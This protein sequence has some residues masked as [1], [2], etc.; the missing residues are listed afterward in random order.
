M[1]LE[2]MLEGEEQGVRSDCW[3]PELTEPQ[4]PCEALAVYS[5]M[6]TTGGFRSGKW[7]ARSSVLKE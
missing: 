2:G 7:P 1:W 6:G 4:G 3:G 5:E